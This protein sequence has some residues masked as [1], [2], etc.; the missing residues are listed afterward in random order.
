MRILKSTVE[1]E[2]VIKKSRFLSQAVSV[3][4]PNEAKYLIKERKQAFADINHVVFA[5]IIGPQGNIMGCSDDGEPSGTAGRP[6]LAVLKGSGITNILLTTIRWFGGIKLGTGGLV[7][8]Y[9]ESARAV[10]AEAETEEFLEMARCSFSVPYSLYEQVKRLLSDLRFR[11]EEEKFT[12]EV[13]ICGELCAE[14]FP[15]L[16]HRLRELSNGAVAV[17]PHE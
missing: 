6:T 10:L 12:D 13:A 17:F 3:D 8:A 9:G 4:D 2:I 15:L 5:F 14:N 11:V 1:A 7:H 16:Q